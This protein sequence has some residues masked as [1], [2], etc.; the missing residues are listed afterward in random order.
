MRRK[1]RQPIGVVERVDLVGGHQHWLV[2][3][4]FPGCIATR[5][6]VEL[7]HDDVEIADRVAS[8][9][10]QIND[11]DE[12]LRTLQV[13]EEAMSEPV[14][15]MCAL[16]QARNVRDNERATVRKTDDAEVG[17]QLQ[18]QRE[19]LPLTGKTGLY[20]GGGAFGQR[21]KRRVA[22]PADA[23]LGDE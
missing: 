2:G 10:R 21:K 19:I 12:D 9:R 5:K 1:A 13:S 14:P 11:M 6:Q 7:A 16:D 3:E 20:A 17:E 18:V 15:G 8:G 22:A 23:S 4:P